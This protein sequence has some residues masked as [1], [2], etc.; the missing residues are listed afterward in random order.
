MIS[1]PRKSNRWRVGEKLN[2]R[3]TGHRDVSRDIEP[4][5]RFRDNVIDHCFD[6]VRPRVGNERLGSSSR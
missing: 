5:V 2:A 3:L 4:F 1:R 6:V